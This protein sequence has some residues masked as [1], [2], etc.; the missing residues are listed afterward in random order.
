VNIHNDF[1]L[2]TAAFVTLLRRPRAVTA[3]RARRAG[4]ST[5]RQASSTDRQVVAGDSGRFAGELHSRRIRHGGRNNSVAATVATTLLTRWCLDGNA[6][7]LR[8]ARRG[9]AHTPP[10]RRLGGAGGHYGTD[11]AAAP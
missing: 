2:A 3:L 1:A 11:I 7:T 9:A 6:R 10:G 8:I 5:I 4:S